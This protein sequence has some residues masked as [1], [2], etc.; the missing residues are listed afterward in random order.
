MTF[1]V[2]PRRGSPRS[3]WDS[4]S[5][6]TTRKRAEAP[7]APNDSIVTNNGSFSETDIGSVLTSIRLAY[8]NSTCPPTIRAAA[9][10]Y[11][12]KDLLCNGCKGFPT[13]DSKDI[14]LLNIPQKERSGS[15]TEPVMQYHFSVNVPREAR[16]VLW[17]TPTC[18]D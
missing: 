10:C 7:P 6:T 15:T 18:T 11:G 5:R 13:S 3:L 12:N 16:P 14:P 9:S 2:Y 1:T 17:R 4:G 8:G